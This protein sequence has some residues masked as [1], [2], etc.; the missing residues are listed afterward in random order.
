MLAH[1]AEDANLVLSLVAYVTRS[2]SAFA[3][4]I[5]EAALALTLIK[6]RSLSIAA[7][8]QA[9]GRLNQLA[10]LQKSRL[11]MACARTAPHDGKLSL[12]ESSAS[13][14]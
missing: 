6:A 13:F 1:V 9:V 7:V 2:D 5:K 3:Q 4:G 14:E 10:P 8:T 12:I 11:V